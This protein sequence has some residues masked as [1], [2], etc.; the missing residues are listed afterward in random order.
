LGSIFTRFKQKWYWWEIVNV[1]KKLTIALLLRGIPSSNAL[2]P[3][4]IIL[5]IGF[6]L[7]MQTTCK[8]WKR[9]M[10]NTMDPIGGI[11]LI[12]SLFASNAQHFNGHKIVLYL[13]L[14]LDLIY[15]IAL[16]ALFVYEAVVRKTN[17]EIIWEARFA[18]VPTE[19]SPS[20]NQ[21]DADKFIHTPLMRLPFTMEDQTTVLDAMDEN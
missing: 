4:F 9:N 1:L 15:L 2:Q 20:L 16:I 19:T 7:L 21:N 14:T 10:E 17:Y 13:A 8:P 11:L 6:P 18:A 3:A 12:S 5:S